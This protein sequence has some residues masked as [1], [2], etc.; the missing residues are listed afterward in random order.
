MQDLEYWDKVVE[1]SKE[2]F[3][4]GEIAKTSAKD[5]RTRKSH[6]RLALLK[7]LSERLSSS[8]SQS[9]ACARGA[10]WWPRGSRAIIPAEMGVAQ[11]T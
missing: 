10:S 4:A 11:S 6:G 2:R 1:I 3:K 9:A 5:A 7:P 8:Y